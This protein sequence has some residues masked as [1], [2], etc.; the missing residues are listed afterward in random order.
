MKDRERF[1]ELMMRANK[2][3]DVIARIAEELEEEGYTRKAQSGMQLVYKIE[4]WQ[5]RG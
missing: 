3:K 1:N 5:N 4:A 2:A